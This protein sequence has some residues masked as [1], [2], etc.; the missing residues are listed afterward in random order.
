MS[1]GTDR[2]VPDAGC[3]RWVRE[4]GLPSSLP[5]KGGPGEGPDISSG[6]FFVP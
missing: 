5:P 2:P 3:R 1:Y 6:P 4:L